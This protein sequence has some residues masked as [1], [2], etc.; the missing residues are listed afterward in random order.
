MHAY[1][2]RNEHVCIY[3]CLCCFYFK[4]EVEKPFPADSCQLNTTT[5]LNLQLALTG[6]DIV[7]HPP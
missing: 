4:K 2:L 3:V 5:E 7:S 1:Y 6:D